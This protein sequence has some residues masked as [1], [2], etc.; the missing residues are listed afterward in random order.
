M[1]KELIKKLSES[2]YRKNL[3]LKDSVKATDQK[4]VNSGKFNSLMLGRFT[5]DDFKPLPPGWRIG[6]PNF[7]GIGTG[8]AGTSWWYALML[9]HP[10]IVQNRLGV[11]ELHYFAHLKYHNLDDDCINAYRQAFA[12]PEGSICGEWSPNYLLHPLCLE[13]IANV[14]PA[15]KILLILRNPVD[16]S[17]SAIN[18][19]LSVRLKNFNFNSEERYIYETYSIYQIAIFHSLYAYGLR[20]LLKNFDRSQILVLQYEKCKDNPQQEIARTYRFLGVDDKYQPQNLKKTVN[21]QEYLIPPLNSEER[22]R[23]TAYFAD[24]VRA[25][26]E[27]FPEIDLSLWSDFADLNLSLS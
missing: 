14:A 22:Q 27:M 25:T 9:Q 26:V 20:R 6:A 7:I 17:I 11:K 5:P 3:V 21:R 12:T 24:D 1:I 23:L 15:T 4:K 13:H 2:I 10:Q 8:K 16:R 18:H 19:Q